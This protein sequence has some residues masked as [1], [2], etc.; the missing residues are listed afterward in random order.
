MGEV[1]WDA[2]PAGLFLGGAPFNVACHLRAAGVPVALVSR[3]GRDGLGD[4]ALRRTA[5][6]GVATDLVQVDPALPTGLVRVTLD[7]A[8]E[9]SFDIP[10]PVAWDAVEPADDLLRRADERWPALQVLS[11]VLG[12]GMSSRLFQ[13]VREPAQC[14]LPCAPRRRGPAR[15]RA[16]GAGD[17]C[18]EVGARRTRDVRDGRLGRGV[19]HC[20][21]GAGG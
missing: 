3:V 4:E 6:Y 12:G 1:L 10:A 18:V 13:Q 9:A 20:G 15:E 7:A 11:T 2:L 16:R 21:E 19:E 8:G 14:G 17:G 5:Q